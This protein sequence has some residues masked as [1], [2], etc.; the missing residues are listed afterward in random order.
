MRAGDAA[1]V[2]NDTTGVHFQV[3]QESFAKFMHQVARA[4]RHREPTLTGSINRLE[5]DVRVLELDAARW[6]RSCL[7]AINHPALEALNWKIY[8][9]EFE[10]GVRIG[11]SGLLDMP[12]LV[13]QSMQDHINAWLISG[14]SGER[15]YGAETGK[16]APTEG[17]LIKKAASILNEKY[18]SAKIADSG[19]LLRIVPDGRLDKV[20][21]ASRLMIT[22]FLARW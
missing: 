22:G 4:A 12:G 18:L 1:I 20:R 16:S 14:P 8:Q 6:V 2:V 9:P 15:W 13:N 17:F 7:F 11:E 10:T 21:N 5:H 3:D 19:Q